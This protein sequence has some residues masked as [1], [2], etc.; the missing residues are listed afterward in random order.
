LVATKKAQEENGAEK[1]KIFEEQRLKE[2]QMKEEFS[3]L[4]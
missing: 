4:K 1:Q 2:Q 3:K